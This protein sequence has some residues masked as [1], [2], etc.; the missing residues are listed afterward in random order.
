MAGQKRANG[1]I[2]AGGKSASL[3]PPRTTFL[4]ATLS[5]ELQRPHG[6]VGMQARVLSIGAGPRFT[7]A[8]SEMVWRFTFRALHQSIDVP[9]AIS[10][11]KT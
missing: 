7:K 1:S 8:S 9:S 10:R 4:G 11:M 5:H 2:N 6:G 3:L